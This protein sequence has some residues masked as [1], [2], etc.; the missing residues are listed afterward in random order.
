MASPGQ[1]VSPGLGQSRERRR[2]PG[3]PPTVRQL[4]EQ[5]D[6]GAQGVQPGAFGGEK[7]RPSA[8]GSWQ[9]REAWEAGSGLRSYGGQGRTCEDGECGLW[10]QARPLPLWDPHPW[11]QVSLS[12]NGL[13]LSQAP[14]QAAP[15]SVAL[16]ALHVP[17][18]P[19]H[20]PP[21]Q[22]FQSLLNTCPSFSFNAGNPSPHRDLS[23]RHL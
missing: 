18:P 19:S 11:A 5:E 14:A 22:L 2:Q 16:L 20:C 9:S 15:P 13:L 23:I 21:A 7:G 3:P 1:D 4:R 12:K 10:A 8:Q 17:Y 6:Q